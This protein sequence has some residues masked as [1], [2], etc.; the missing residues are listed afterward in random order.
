M[1]I[2]IEAINWLAVLAAIV[3]NMAVGAIWYSPLAMGNAWIKSTG[4]TPEEMQDGGKAMATVIVP[5]TL[6]ALILAVLVQATG[7]HSAS[8]GALLGFLVWAGFV[9]PTN[10]IEIIFDRKSYRTAAINNGNFIITFPL[11]GAILGLWG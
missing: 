5:A 7:I 4:H 2:S 9:L 8:G 1:S 3:G 10:W 6:N 11:M